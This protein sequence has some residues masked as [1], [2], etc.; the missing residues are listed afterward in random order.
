MTID[1]TVA[2]MLAL[3]ENRA[4]LVRECAEDPL[5]A[6]SVLITQVTAID[7]LRDQVEKL[8]RIAAEAC[9]Y[10]VDELQIDLTLSG[11]MGCFK[12]FRD[13][14]EHEDFDHE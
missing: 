7:D 12:W 9:A 10:A 3:P 2:N 8:E 14:P 5:A 13:Y 6:A 1:L 4:A 11:L